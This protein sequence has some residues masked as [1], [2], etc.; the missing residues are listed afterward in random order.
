MSSIKN[1]DVLVHAEG[2]ATI[3]FFEPVSAEAEEFF[4]EN[5]IAEGWQ[6]WGKSIAVDHREGEQL[7]IWL[8]KRGYRLL[9]VVDFKIQNTGSTKTMPINIDWNATA[10][11]PQEQERLKVSE[12][13]REEIFYGLRGAIYATLEKHGVTVFEGLRA[14]IGIDE[15]IYGIL[16]LVTEIEREEKK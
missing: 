2:Y 12:K 10:Y 13:R 16:S 1:I 7:A 6:Y 14:E 15:L 3:W 9:N 4:A 5:V 8:C 11:F